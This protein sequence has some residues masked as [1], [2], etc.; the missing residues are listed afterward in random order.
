MF[1]KW[2][3]NWNKDNPTNIFGPAIAVGVAGSA[4]FVAAMIVA[5]GQPFKTESQQT[6]PRGTGTRHLIAPGA[7]FLQPRLGIQNGSGVFDP[8]TEVFTGP[9]LEHLQGHGDNEWIRIFEHRNGRPNGLVALEILQ[10]LQS[11][12]THL[13]IGIPE[14]LD[15]ECGP[16]GMIPFLQHSQRRFAH[17]QVGVQRS[18]KQ[19]RLSVFAQRFPGRIHPRKGSDCHLPMHDSTQ[20]PCRMQRGHGI[21]RLFNH[22]RHNLRRG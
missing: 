15:D 11:Q 2:F 10:V 5:F 4:V 13:Q 17:V 9:F 8:D 1:P 12:Q 16:R 22:V 3:D 21:G 18:R 14:L 7:V 6:G 19:E 20:V